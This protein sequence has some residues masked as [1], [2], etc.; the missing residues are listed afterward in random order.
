MGSL[1][2]KFL[3]RNLYKVPR[4]I[5]CNSN[6]NRVDLIDNFGIAADRIKVIHNPVDTKLILEVEEVEVFDKSY[7]NF[8][9]I[10]RLDSNKNFQMMIQAFARISR[11]DL[12]LYILG[13]GVEYENLLE[14]IRTMSL[15]NKVFLVGEVNNPFYYLKSADAFLFTSRSEGFPNVLLEALVSGVFIISHNCKSGA[16]EILFDKMV[17]CE[18]ILENHFGMLTPYEK[19]DKFAEA[20]ALFI[21]RR[22]ALK[23]RRINDLNEKIQKYEKSL[24]VKEYIKYLED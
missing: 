4:K 20:I 16:D 8:I 24:V 7:I 2:N 13:A 18:E 17:E 12:R 6:G 5:I 15:Q 10:G 22:E 14:L 19:V 1:V 23:V 3:I 21:S 11:D 9:S